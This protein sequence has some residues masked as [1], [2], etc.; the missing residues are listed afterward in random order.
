MPIQSAGDTAAAPPV[1]GCRECR[2]TC[3]RYATL[4]FNRPGIGKRLAAS[5]Q[6]I[7]SHFAVLLRP[8]QRAPLLSLLILGVVTLAIPNP[9]PSSKETYLASGP[10]N[11]SPVTLTATS[12]DTPELA[13]SARL[14]L[15]PIASRWTVECHFRSL[16]THRSSH[17]V[18]P[19]LQDSISL[20]SN[21]IRT[22]RR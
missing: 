21:P 6:W 9:F 2:R 7:E 10:V 14:L 3:V 16:L 22:R 4:R 8:M 12:S 15:K 17:R 5:C 18:M 19:T 1:E 11:G 20:E 13:D